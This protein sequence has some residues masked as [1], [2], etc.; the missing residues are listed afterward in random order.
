MGES[1]FNSIKYQPIEKRALD[2]LRSYNGNNNFIIILK[3]RVLRGETL[4]GKKLSE[5]VVKNH[6]KKVLGINKWFDID[7]YFSDELQKKFLTAE[8]PTKIF[9]KK[10][11]ADTDKAVHVW[12]KIWEEQNCVDIWVPKHSII[13]Q[14]KINTVSFSDDHWDKYERRPYKHQ[15][16][17]IIK[18]LEHDKFIL[19]DDQGVGKTLEAVTAAV[20]SKVKKILIVCPASLKLNWKKEIEMV[21]R[22]GSINIID[23][24][25]WIS[26][27]KWTIINYDILQNFHTVPD[28]RK[29]DQK[30]ITNIV[31]ENFDLIIGDEIHKCK[32]KDAI[33]T[34]IFNDISKHV[35]RLWLLTGTP[36]TNRPIDFFN[37][38]SL[39]EHRLAKNWVGYV[40]R[41]CA[42]KQFYGKGGR[43]V[44]D[45]K[46]HSNLD[47]LHTNTQ[48]IILRRR[49]EDVLDLPEKI[50][51]PIYQPLQHKQEYEKIVGEYQSW[52]EH[53]KN[54][55]LALHL[56]QLVKLRQFL[57]LSKIDS[58]IE[59]AENAIEEGRKVVIFTNFTEPLLLLHNHFGKRSVIHHGPMSKDRREESITSFQNDD[60]VKVFIGNIMSAGV[61]ITL[62]AGD[63]VIFNDLSWL[64]SDHLQAQD[65]CFR[66]GQINKVNVYYNIIDE[67]LDLHLF[68]SLMKKMKNIDLIMG[69]SN[70]DEGLF[71]DVIMKLK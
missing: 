10:I 19:G 42:G 68:E 53:Q 49:K 14:D 2:I 32:N 67:T 29:K 4:I 31:D 37:L 64:P 20:E 58:T 25:K 1:E 56:A 35:K 18:L 48:D 66:I 51:Q 44:W 52:A 54:V 63:F 70:V 34:K 71:K 7:L 57:A 59:M 5:Y 28:K 3:N 36:V 50:V 65:R 39:C 41:F 33:R 21:E 13:K 12:G 8:K 17:G 40:I 46:G 45:T 27:G 15:I 62:T 69:D 9:I 47:E 61:G 60:N 16:E 6:D 23:G 11:L 26:G 30:L 22:S 24:K 38:L 55:N 43:K